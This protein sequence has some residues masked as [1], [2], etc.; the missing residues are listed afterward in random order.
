MICTLIPSGTSKILLP[1]QNTDQFFFAGGEKDRNPNPCHWKREVR[2]ASL[3]R[4]QMPISRQVK[5]AALELKA[6]EGIVLYS[7]TSS[8]YW[9][10]LLPGKKCTMSIL[11]SNRK[12]EVTF[13]CESVLNQC[14]EHPWLQDPG[15]KLCFSYML[16]ELWAGSDSYPT[17]DL[18]VFLIPLDHFILLKNQTQT[19]PSSNQT[20]WNTGKK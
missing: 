1:R 6:T 15:K 5:H 3:F 17:A 2:S 9:I 11:L 10:F 14:L 20:P 4:P 18:N 16:A 19:K 12:N 7:N 13:Q 8:K